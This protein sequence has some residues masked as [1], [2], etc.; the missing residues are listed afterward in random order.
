M[1]SRLSAA[2]LMIVSFQAVAAVPDC[3]SAEAWPASMAFAT[4]KNAQLLDNDNVDFSKTRVV[5]LSSGNVG[6]NVYKQIHDV[7]FILKSGDRVEAITR[8]DASSDECSMSAVDV[9][10]I[11][12]HLGG[13]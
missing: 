2:V 9:Y 5:R 3:T 13:H 8:N 11:S 6:K 10:V 7:T 1:R 4:L 12:K